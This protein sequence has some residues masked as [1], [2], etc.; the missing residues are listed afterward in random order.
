MDDEIPARFRTL[1]DICKDPNYP[2]DIRHFGIAQF[3]SGWVLQRPG[4][5]G[6]AISLPKRENRW[7]HAGCIDKASRGLT[8]QQSMFEGEEK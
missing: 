3:T 5:G 2:I 7:A 8:G 6:H 4:G 1:C